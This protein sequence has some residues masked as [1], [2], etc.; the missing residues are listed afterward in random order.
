MWVPG[1][2]LFP[3]VVSVGTWCVFVP[4]CFDAQGCNL[5]GRFGLQTGMHVEC[6][7]M[8]TLNV[9]LCAPLPCVKQ[10][11]HVNPSVV[12]CVRRPTGDE[13][14]QT[15]GLLVAVVDMCHKYCSCV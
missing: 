12:Y 14:A 4:S 2:C 7:S 5:C 11:E 3:L 6:I 1:V 13:V 8:I 15:G 10:Q 9:F